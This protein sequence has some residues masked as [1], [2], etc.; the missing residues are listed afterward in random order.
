M[1]EMEEMGEIGE[2]YK[3]YVFHE[4]GEKIAILLDF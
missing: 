1:G 4:K 3:T 2:K